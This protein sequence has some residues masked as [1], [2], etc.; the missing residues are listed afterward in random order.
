MKKDQIFDSE[1]NGVD[2]IRRKI[3]GHTLV[4]ASVT[5]F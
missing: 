1:L 2:K 4:N 3:S 5:M